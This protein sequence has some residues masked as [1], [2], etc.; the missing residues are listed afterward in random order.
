MEKD[1]NEE[2]L[3]QLGAVSDETKGIEAEEY[4]ENL[5]VCNKRDENFDECP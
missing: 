3:F 5:T 1:M 4:L 2:I